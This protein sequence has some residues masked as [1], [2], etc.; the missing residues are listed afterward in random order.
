MKVLRNVDI[1]N[2]VRLALS[3][4]FMTY[5]RPLPEKFLV[6]SVTIRAAG[7]QSENTIDSFTVVLDA[8][9]KEDAD[10]YE[11]LRT[12]LAVLEKQAQSQFG[13]LRNVKVN[14]LGSWGND[15][16]RPDLALSSATVQVTAH[17]EEIEIEIES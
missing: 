11:L 16:V 1:E 5:V 10:S 6:P 3:D 2:E 14:S 9:A 12:A 7:G 15:P 8:R 4:Y 17:R 13:A